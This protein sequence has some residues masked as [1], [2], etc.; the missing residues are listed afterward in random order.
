M[1]LYVLVSV[2]LFVS[3]S[4]QMYGRFAAIKQNV[5]DEFQAKIVSSEE[6]VMYVINPK[7]DA[8]LMD[9]C[10]I[11]NF[12]WDKILAQAEHLLKFI[13]SLTQ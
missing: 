5:N 12:F 2:Y 6:A 10:C 3:V 8:S 4:V 13:V 9:F 11:I 1:L 7:N